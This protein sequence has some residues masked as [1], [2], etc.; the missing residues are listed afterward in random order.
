MVFSRKP[1]PVPAEAPAPQL[2]RG[3]GVE[4]QHLHAV[5]SAG[6]AATQ[7]V[8]GNDLSIEG[9][10]ITIR[11]KGSLK[12][13]G[14]IQADL[15]SRQLEVGK[16]AVIQGAIAAETVD[17][18]G[19]VNGAIMGTHVVLH[20]TAEVEGDI[21][22]HLLS[23]EQGAAFDGRSRRVNDPSQI[24][25]QLERPGG[26]AASASTGPAVPPAV[27]TYSYSTNG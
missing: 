7:S 4:K 21:H 18:F 19:R 17:V 15:H 2:R 24:A 10:T 22:S 11:C 1:E 5:A 14:N 9:E 27:P 12:V 25:P 23:I 20:A 3:N 6:A 26:L 16:E 8:I 13:L